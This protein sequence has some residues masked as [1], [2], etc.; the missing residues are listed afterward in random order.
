MASQFA[1]LLTVGMLLLNLVLAI[2]TLSVRVIRR[3]QAKR[4]SILQDEF[5]REKLFKSKQLLRV[6]NQVKERIS[7]HNADEQGIYDMILASKSFRKAKRN[8]RSPLVLHRIEACA[9]LRNLKGREVDDLLL[10]TFKKEKNQVV[11][12][13]LFQIL[14]NHKIEEA[15]EPMIAK[16]GKATT[17][18]ATRYQQLLLTFGPDLRPYLMDQLA[19][20]EIHIQV[21]ICAYSLRWP[22]DSLVEYLSHLAQHGEAQVEALAL[23]ALGRHFPQEL[24]KE[25]FCSST[26][27]NT[28][29]AVIYAYSR[30][31]QRNS[32]LQ[33]LKHTDNAQLQETI[34]NA[35][36]DMVTRLPSLLPFLEQQFEKT[37]ET[38]KQLILAK[39]LDTNLDYL[40]QNQGEGDLS[41]STVRLIETL[42]KAYHLSNIIG[43]LNA[44]D[45]N[46]HIDRIIHTMRPLALADQELA[47]QLHLYLKEEVFQKFR[48]PEKKIG[49]DEN[50]PHREKPQRLRLILLLAITIVIFPIII[51]ITELTSI[52]DMPFRDIWKLYIVRFNYL[53]VFYSLSVNAIYI[54]ILILSFFSASRQ[55]RLW[56]SKGEQLLFTKG[57][58]PSVSIIAPA[59]NE[60]ANIIESTNSLLNQHYPDFELIIVNDGSKDNTLQTLIT[61][62]DLER[63]DVMIHSRLQTRPLRGVYRNKNIPNLVVV[64]KYNGGKADSLNLGLNAATKEFFCGI[65]ADSLLESD[66]LLK[67]VSIMLDHKD[68]S[69]ASGGNICPVNGC[70]VELGH[71][72]SISVPNTFLARLQSLEYIRSFMTGR[73]GWARMNLLLII[74][75]AFGV[76]HR[77]RTISTGGYLT[78]S[79]IYKKDTVGEDMELVV[80]LSRYMREQGLAYRVQYACNANCWTEVPQKWKPLHRQR[81]RWHRGLIDIMLFHSSMIGN[82][83]YGSLGMVGMLY[84][85]LFELL[86]PFIEVQGLLFVG[87]AAF[88]HILNLTV[89]LLLFA[90]TILM[91]TVVSMLAV[92]ISE[93]DQELYPDRDIVRL[94]GM[95]VVENFGF[96][97]LISL[98]RVEAYFTAMRKDKGW[99]SQ[100]RTGFKTTAA[101]KKSS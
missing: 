41:K 78:K 86:G 10:E 6:F 97:Q 18:M 23:K 16:L 40:L 17:W 98:W 93:F 56:R 42:C 74:S 63:E 75:G 9:K 68:E 36:H 89:A 5:H 29:E 50:Q 25:P 12:L 33:I 7:F 4:M 96:R 35:L 84:Y 90:T 34:I 73:I 88:A 77:E 81:N 76:F 52:L 20:D 24:I 46:P 99:G 70:T 19:S 43:F 66:S 15:I 30:V 37:K 101:K 28:I 45:D 83:R 27:E 87:I 54:A 44:S 38:G 65:D 72:D 49:K 21:L 92:L 61:Y 58:L 95:A 71:L 22:T 8:L 11:L 67:A 3:I 94:L 53:L 47:N 26:D 100:V 69:I 79:G 57:L 64:D 51:L 31:P 48:L 1:V 82:P 39:V 85:F 62:F 13:Y 2:T 59:Y 91:G 55:N 14:S 32:I 80:R 60:E